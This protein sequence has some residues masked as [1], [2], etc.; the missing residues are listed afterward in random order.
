MNKSKLLLGFSIVLTGTLITVSTFNASS[1]KSL[2]SSIT[3]DG[4]NRTFT[5]NTPLNIEDGVGTASYGNLSVYAPNCESIENGVA[6]LNNGKLII[7]CPSAGVDNKGNT[8][9]FT[10]STIGAISFIYNNNNV[11]TT[12]RV[13]W[14][15]LTSGGTIEGAGTGSYC[16]S[17]TAKSYE[18]QTIST[19]SSDNNYLIN[20]SS[21]KSNYS[22]ITLVT[23]GSAAFDLI[24]LTISFTCK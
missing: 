15:R 9:G 19:N 16:G 6:H 2:A 11:N 8:I 7:Y 3:E 18:N 17:D 23:S 20:Q 14:G 21:F 5:L 10:G 12:I 24:S 22:C 1:Y 13:G 4:K